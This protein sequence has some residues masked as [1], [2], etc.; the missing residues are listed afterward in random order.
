MVQGGLVAYLT[1]ARGEEVPEGDGGGVRSPSAHRPSQS[2][3]GVL[4]VV[5]ACAVK[6][7]LLTG[8][9]QAADVP[10]VPVPAPVFALSLAAP[11]EP[12]VEKPL[13]ADDEE[14]FRWWWNLESNVPIYLVLILAP[15]MNFKSATFFTKFNSVGELCPLPCWCFIESENRMLML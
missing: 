9:R 10:L 1:G 6:C 13:L 5:V 12:L 14:T 7:H 2:L 11:V 8:T 4:T 15:L 3:R